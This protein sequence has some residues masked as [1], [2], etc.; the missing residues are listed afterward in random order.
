MPIKSEMSL[1]EQQDKMEHR[2]AESKDRIQES[3][4]L[5]TNSRVMRLASIAIAVK[6]IRTRER[7]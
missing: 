3:R 6:R 5:I 1:V 7:N 2:I 4:E